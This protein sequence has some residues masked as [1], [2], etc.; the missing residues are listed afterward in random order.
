MSP[1]PATTS[2][3]AARALFALGFRPFFLLAG[4]AAVALMSAWLGAY[5]AGWPASAY[6]GP[7]GWH[8][9][10]M[11]FGYAGAVLAGFLLTA[12]RNWTGR[13]TPSG[14]A[15]AAL[16]GLWLAGRVLPLIPSSPGWLIGVADLAFLPAL[17][18]V[19]TPLLWRAGQRRNLV[20]LVLIALMTLA[21]A[22]VHLDRLHLLAGYPGTR[23]GLTF[24]IG[25][26]VLLIAIVGGRVIPF[27]IE[28]GAEV[29]LR[30]HRWLDALAVTSVA[31]WLAAS[32]LAHGGPAQQALAWTAALF[33]A[34][35]LALWHDRRLWSV[36]LLWVL[37]LGYGWLVAG[38]ALDGAALAGWVAALA[39][40][41]AFTA[42][43]IGVLTLGMMA[44]V[45]LGHTARPMRA[46]PAT[47]LAFV[48]INLAAL[49]RVALPLVAPSFYREAILASGLL[50]IGAFV[51]FLLVYTPILTRPRL[52]DRA[53]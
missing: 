39:A 22:L 33:N 19:L 8:G 34:L 26:F 53:G 38:L 1:S 36:P 32:V 29:S 25:L 3:P 45:A 28:R 4:I 2:Q 6:Y 46:A 47:V 14:A 52:D 21:N 37:Y 17:A 5:L 20:F 12:V 7:L 43:A 13:D 15:L 35:R 31:L 49:I 42:G 41:H 23:L 30:P 27:F 44:R 9:H 24:A 18:A 11:L 40:L 51:I 48:L 16:A 50:W 10:E